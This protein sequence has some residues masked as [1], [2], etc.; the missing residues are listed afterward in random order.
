MVRRLMR[1]P[2]RRTY[3][4][5]KRSRYTWVVIAVPPTPI[6]AGTFQP[7]VLLTPLRPATN[8]TEEVYQSMTNPLVSAIM[9][10]VSVTV[11]PLNIQTDNA[12]NVNYAW[13][14]D[15]DDD[16]VN[17]ASTLPPFTAGNSNNWM[18]H[19]SGY[20]SVPSAVST[21][22]GNNTARSGTTDLYYRRYE[23]NMRKYKRRLD[24]TRDSLIFVVENAPAPFSDEQMLV[25]AYF[26]LLLVE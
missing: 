7:F 15:T 19:R 3:G 11:D 4:A 22:G 20:I 25:T 1:R 8:L 24:S 13:G 10:H 5:K 9:G 18:M 14:I 26:R 2:S 17:A 21:T 23:L 12:R 6:S 16:F